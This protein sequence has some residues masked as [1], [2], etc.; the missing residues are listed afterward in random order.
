MIQKRNGSKR[1]EVENP[2]LTVKRKKKLQEA[3]KV[4]RINE[5]EAA[6]EPQP[7]DGD[8]MVIIKKQAEGLKASDFREDRE[9][10]KPK[11]TRC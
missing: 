2:I 10:V 8:V 6:R 3:Q 9:V 1:T 4:L 11:S 7:T 5:G